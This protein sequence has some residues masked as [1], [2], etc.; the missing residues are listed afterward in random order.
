MDHFIVLFDG[1]C[2]LCNTA[3][4]FIIRRDPRARFRFAALQSDYARNLMKQY[5]VTVDADKDKLVSIILVANN[6]IYSKSDAALKIAR[7][8][9]GLWPAFWVFKA[10]PRFLRDTAYE[11]IARNRYRLFGKK[12]QCMI[13]TPELKSR[14]IA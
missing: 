4:Q 10:V 12:D 8:L 5:G 2:N 1:V 3:V 14:F 6:R 7:H 9:H 11:W 13:P